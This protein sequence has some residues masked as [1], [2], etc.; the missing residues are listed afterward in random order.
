MMRE[1]FVEK[2]AGGIFVGLIVAGIFY[3]VGY[4]NEAYNAFIS[5][6]PVIGKLMTLMETC[7]L[8]NVIH[9][10]QFKSW[11]NVGLL[12]S[13]LASVYVT[14]WT[15]SIIGDRKGKGAFIVKIF[16]CFISNCAVRMIWFEGVGLLFENAMT[17]IEAGMSDMWK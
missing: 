15:D 5:N 6:I 11:D 4:F 13:W 9:T 14:V 2:Y 10:E 12:V 7:H 16:V 3:V 17:F 8:L 1:N